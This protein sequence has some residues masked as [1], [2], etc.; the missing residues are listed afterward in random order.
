MPE[1]QT[2]PVRDGAI[3]LGQFLKLTG[4]IGNGA[5]AKWYLAENEVW[6]NG[7]AENRR[8]RQLK[9]GDVVGVEGREFE[10]GFG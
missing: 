2:V 8:G 7:E 9:T 1:R 10:V 3:T 5:E 6:V 4:V